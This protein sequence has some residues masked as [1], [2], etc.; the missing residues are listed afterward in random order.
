MDNILLVNPRGLSSVQGF[1]VCHRVVD[2][3]KGIES[4]EV[5]G[6]GFCRVQV[7]VYEVVTAEA[8]SYRILLCLVPSLCMVVDSANDV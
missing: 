4:V 8:A 1:S 6:E 7:T 3:A 2:G 5:L